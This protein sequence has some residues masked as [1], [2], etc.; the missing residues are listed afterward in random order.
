M[1]LDIH[2]N[3]RTLFALAG[4]S[5][6]LLVVLVAILPAVAQE[7]A[8]PAPPPSGKD[9]VEEGRRLYASWNCN[10]CHTQLI[11]GDE[12]YA[13]WREVPGVQPGAKPELYLWWPTL[14]P[15]SRFGLDRPS[16]PEE[17]AGQKPPFLGTQRTGPDLMA[18]GTR[19][20]SRTWHYWH[21]F[22]PRAVSPDSNMPAMPW[23]FHTSET[24]QPEDE[25]VP[26]LFALEE[27]GVPRGILY[28]TPD[29]QALVEYLVD[30]TRE[31]STR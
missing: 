31:Q 26:P 18:V 2:T 15:D 5:Y 1:K 13:E 27:L 14:K 6:V 10:T 4:G 22:A 29:A 3:H 11:R 8:Y 30:L 17:Y 21:L 20:P 28:A 16:R 24:K 25:K 12:R 23:L 9:L 19:L 7:R